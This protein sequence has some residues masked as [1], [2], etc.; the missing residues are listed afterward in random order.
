M[1]IGSRFIVA[2]EIRL[3]YS[4]PF[5]AALEKS[6]LGLP[7]S[8]SCAKLGRRVER[9]RSS[10]HI[11]LRQKGSKMCHEEKTEDEIA[12]SIDSGAVGNSHSKREQMRYDQT[13]QGEPHGA[14]VDGALLRL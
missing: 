6:S 12:A 11:S 7:R 8:T 5:R 2:S 1:G 9:E 14:V 4:E 13:Q 10:F 3:R